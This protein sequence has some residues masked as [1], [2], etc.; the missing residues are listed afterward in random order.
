MG[1]ITYFESGSARWLGV[2]EDWQGKVAPGEPDVRYKVLTE[3]RGATPGIQLVEFDP[4]HFETPHSHPESEV[5]YV[6]EGEM[7][8]GDLKLGAGSGVFIEKD[9]VYG[10]LRTGPQGARFL[11][12]GF[13]TRAG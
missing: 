9:T 3:E 7:S 1:D 8:V 13:G 11:R 5:L 10:P 2:P 4:R 6:L 12:V